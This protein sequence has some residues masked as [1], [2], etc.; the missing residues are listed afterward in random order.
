MQAVAP[1]Y[2]AFAAVDL[3]WFAFTLFWFWANWKQIDRL[4]GVLALR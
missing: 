4:Q 3:H 1:F 2:V